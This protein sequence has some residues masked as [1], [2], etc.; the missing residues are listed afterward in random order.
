MY[1]YRQYDLIQYPLVTEKS[2]LIGEE[3]KYVFVVQKNAGKNSIKKALE[4]IF[5]VKVKSI[6][7]MNTKGK[8]KIFK[9]V[10]GRRSGVKK[11]IVTLE[12]DYSIDL[13]AFGVK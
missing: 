9:G 11:S 8:T 13:S 5:N 7:I 1:K 4:S 12:K 6:N 3:G 10:K 2:T